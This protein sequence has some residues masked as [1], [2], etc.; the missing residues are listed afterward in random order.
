MI[1]KAQILKG[2]LEGCILEV[3]SRGESYG[4]QITEDLNNMGLP[5]LN[6]GSV[7]PVLIRL[8]KKGLLR[9]ESKKSPLGPKRKYFNLTDSGHDYLKDFKEAWFDI[10]NSV[11]SIMEGGSHE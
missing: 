7:Y 1:D 3:I 5:D 10:S 9:S 8:Q 4:Y 6:E 11:T 2:L